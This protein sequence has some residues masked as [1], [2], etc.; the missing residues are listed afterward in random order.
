MVTFTTTGVL[1]HGACENV[2]KLYLFV[3][4]LL[5]NRATVIEKLLPCGVVDDTAE[6]K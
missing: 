5:E 2:L 6:N 3:V 1:F 4:R